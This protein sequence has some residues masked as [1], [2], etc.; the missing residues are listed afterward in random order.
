MSSA[1]TSPPRRPRPLPSDRTATEGFYGITSN[2]RM[3][4]PRARE[5]DIR[6]RPGR[7]GHRPVQDGTH[8]APRSVAL[9]GGR[10]IRDARGSWRSPNLLSGVLWAI[11]KA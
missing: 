1:D 9:P 7:V 4:A 6:E 11:E 10:G 8:Q 5:T 3:R 2:V